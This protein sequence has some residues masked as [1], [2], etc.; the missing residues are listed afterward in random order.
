MDLFHGIASI[1]HG[2]ES[3]LVNVRRFDGVYLVFEHGY[4]GGGLFEGVFMSFLTFEG[5]PSSYTKK[6]VSQSFNLENMI[7][8]YGNREASKG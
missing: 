2:K 7:L 4:L 1:L 3:F 6:I 5:S 8:S